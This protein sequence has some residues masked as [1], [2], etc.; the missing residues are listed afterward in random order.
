[1]RTSRQVLGGER[2]LRV[3]GGALIIRKVR[4]RL[5]TTRVALGQWGTALTWGHL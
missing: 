5:A 3:E 2:V 4:C 1:M